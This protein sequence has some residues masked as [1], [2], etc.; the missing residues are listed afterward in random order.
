MKEKS[1]QMIVSRIPL[2]K[3]WQRDFQDV[4]HTMP[5]SCWID[6]LSFFW[7]TVCDSNSIEDYSLII[8][9]RLAIGE[10]IN[11]REWIQEPVDC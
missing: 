11:E 4:I 6:C 9:K 8:C 1:S 2:I 5:M 3:R 7:S 10:I